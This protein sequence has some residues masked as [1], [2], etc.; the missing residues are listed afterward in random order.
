LPNAKRLG[1]LRR[2]TL[3]WCRSTRISASNAA[4]GRNSPIKAYQINLQR[5]LI[6]REYQPI[7]G[8]GQPFWVCGR[9]RQAN[10]VIT[11]NDAFFFSQ[12]DRVVAL[13][14]GNKLAAVHPEAEFV[15]AGGLL[16]YGA[17]LSDLFGRAAFY[18]DKILKGA[19]QADIPIEQPS[20]FDLVVN[21]KAV[22][23]LGLTVTSGVSAASRRGDR[24]KRREFIAC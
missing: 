24:M 21:L 1:D 14:L 6:G 5:S 15:E 22:R 4:R 17:N 19:K 11:L 7:R 16:S 12:R 13:T 3:S 9:D 8:L 2:R 10:G 18:V 20:K 23:T